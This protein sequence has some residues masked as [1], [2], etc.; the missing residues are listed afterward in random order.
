M[1]V[2]AFGLL[3]QKAR[4]G[5][6]L[7]LDDV[8]SETRLAK[9]YL[10]A[11][12][13]ESLNELPGGAYNRAYLRTYATFLGL[14]PDELMRKYEQ[15]EAT[16]S[17]TGRLSA[18]PDALE[19]IRQ[20]AALRRDAARASANASPRGVVAVGGVL[21]LLGTLWWFDAARFAAPVR[22]VAVDSSVAITTPADP[23]SDPGVAPTVAPAPAG[24]NTGAA[25]EAGAK[26]AGPDS[27]A[28]GRDTREVIADEGDAVGVQS[29][30]PAAPTNTVNAA[31][32]V[33]VPTD[34]PPDTGLTVPQ[35]GVGTGVVDRQLVG[36]AETFSVGARVVFW[37]QIVGG[38][39][40]DAVQHVWLHNGEI[41][42]VVDLPVGGPRWRT[43]S[44]RTLES[45]AQGAWVVEARDSG[46]R[47]LARHEFRCE[48]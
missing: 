33:A 7:S 36:Q 19:T 28:P 14:N 41:A 38:G 46:G 37:T 23:Q 5:Q 43:Q 25:T 10:Q 35:S 3:L 24:R 11:L 18:R 15:E 47:V 26:S 29:K 21:A 2:T 42:G 20:A 48:S 8:A 44:R 6:G 39:S 4:D 32:A 30:E 17:R 45:D 40:G 1:S 31:D 12:E 13:S 16:Q 22:P 9:R 34:V 27:E